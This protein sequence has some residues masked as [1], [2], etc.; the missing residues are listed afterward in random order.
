MATAFGPSVPIDQSRRILGQKVA[1]VS[2]AHGRHPRLESCPEDVWQAGRSDECVRA[3]W[4][5][6]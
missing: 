5:D 4:V 1:P 6:S 2:P 3:V